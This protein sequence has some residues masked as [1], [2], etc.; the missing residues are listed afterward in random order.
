MKRKRFFGRPLKKTRGWKKKHR[1]VVKV[2][3][4]TDAGFKLC[5]F[6]REFY[7]SRD[8]FAWFLGAS[9]YEVQ[10]VVLIPCTCEDPLNCV[11]CSDHPG[12]HFRWEL[13]DVDLCTADFAHSE[14]RHVYHAASAYRVKKRKS[15]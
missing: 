7:V 2:I 6:N 14:E 4:V 13:L 9:H 8:V 12:D 15:I 5:T 1:A 10:S 3:D 11:C